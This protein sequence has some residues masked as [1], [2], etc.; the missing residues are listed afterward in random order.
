MKRA[1]QR[2]KI[3]YSADGQIKDKDLSAI[4]FVDECTDEMP[5]DDAIVQSLTPTKSQSDQ[6]HQIEVVLT[7][8]EASRPGTS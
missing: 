8:S 1:I 7:S 3:D 5:E 4:K 6:Q 2:T